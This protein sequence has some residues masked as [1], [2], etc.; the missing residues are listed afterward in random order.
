MRASRNAAG[1]F[2][3]LGP[4]GALRLCALTKLIQ[5]V[6]EPD[7]YQAVAWRV[8]ILC[9]EAPVRWFATLRVARFRK[10]PGLAPHTNFTLSEH[11]FSPMLLR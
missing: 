5:F 8:G 7:R 2:W 9:Y 10:F 6:A 11:A 3:L 1:V 4:V